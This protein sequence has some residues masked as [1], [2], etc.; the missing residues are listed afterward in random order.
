MTELYSKATEI[1]DVI[2]MRGCLEFGVYVAL[3][4]GGNGQSIGV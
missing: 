2:R 3:G 4:N 1:Q